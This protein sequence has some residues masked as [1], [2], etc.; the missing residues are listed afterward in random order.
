M[1]EWNI[2]YAMHDGEG[3][4]NEFMVIL[5]SFLKVLWWFIGKGRNAC[6]IYI[7]TS[8]RV[9]D[10]EKYGNSETDTGFGI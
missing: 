9:E 7:W 1:K 2:S 10:E 6:H 8:N 4:L 3:G 5:P